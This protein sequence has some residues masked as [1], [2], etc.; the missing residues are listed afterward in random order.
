MD[1]SRVG[2]WR[3][4]HSDPTRLVAGDWSELVEGYGPDM[5][6]LAYFI[7]GDRDLASDAV[8]SAWTRAW[9]RRHTL[10]DRS[11]IRSWLLR[12]AGNEA[13]RQLSRR[14]LGRLLELR[15]AKA[16]DPAAS[17]DA[18]ADLAVALSRLSSEDRELL[19]LRH[20]T[21]MT[22]AEIAA[23]TG[24]NDGAVRMHLSRLH[25]RLREE[26]RDDR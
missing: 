3:R 9:T 26:L 4:S 16:G 17:L 24:R 19:G 7:C 10:R 22:S 5:L 8:Q 21:G 6:R 13:R 11:Q 14:R 18:N 15:S 25:R 12:I 2:P 20:V 1:V 23:L